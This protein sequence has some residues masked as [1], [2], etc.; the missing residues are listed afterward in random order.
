MPA[1]DDAPPGPDDT[2]GFRIGIN[3]SALTLGG[4][5]MRQYALQ[6]LPWM[7]RLSPHR[8]V[9]FY[10]LQGWPSLA[11]VLRRLGPAERGRVEAVEIDRQE[12]VFE[13]AHH[14]DVYFSPLN[15]LGPDLLDR[16]TLSTIADVQEQFFPQYF[17]AEQLRGRALVYPHTA[18]AVTTL[19]TLSEFSKKSICDA[20]GVPPDRVRAIP[21]AANDDIVGACPHW[22]HELGEPPDRFIFYP[23]N[24]YPHKDH[25]TLL[26][27]LVLL[28]RRGIDCGGVLTGQP[29]QPG[30]DIEAE[31]A[32]RGLAGRVRWLGHV[33]A[34]TLRWLYENALALCFP[35][36][37]EG[38]GMPLVEAMLCGCPVV[39]TASSCIPE[40][41]GDAA[42]LVEP[43]AEAFAD[44]VAGLLADPARRSDL[45]ARGR[46]R[47][48]QFSARR[49]AADT[50][51]AIEDAVASFHPSRPQGAGA[52]TITFVVRP[53]AGGRALADTLA[54]IAFEAE[55]HDEVFVL[56]APEQLDATAQA[57]CANMG[58]VRFV[59][60]RRA[61]WLQAVGRDQVWLLH[62]GEQVSEGAT[63]AALAV[64]AAKPGASA[65]VGQVLRRASDG[66]LAG[67]D[68]M[69]PRAGQ[70]RQ[71]GAVPGCAVVWRTAFLRGQRARVVGPGWT[72]AILAGVGDVA[73]VYRTFATTPPSGPATPLG[74][75]AAGARALVRRMPAWVQRP[76]R[77]LY[78]RVAARGRG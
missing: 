45:I 39:A 22:P 65:A 76:L 41:V 50:L 15:G 43:T 38:F 32:R 61:D 18:H 23:A 73:F 66:G 1:R 28:H 44:A 46:A 2:R 62:E 56:A 40:T 33:A 9:V 36:R 78:R 16:P 52:G 57:L 13:H 54:S 4:G 31:I 5:G 12:Q 34:P 64:L 74:R 70:P 37:F 59:E 26:D 58:V 24:L 68:Y 8:L 71:W 30:I 77:G 72:A 7:L 42:L 48:A 17:T 63:R 3:L 67:V 75:R 51:R 29:A 35:S 25:A 6:L 10:H 11:T 60:P 69:P 14:F 19:L 20:F 47:A 21:L 55:E 53:A 27:A 49:L